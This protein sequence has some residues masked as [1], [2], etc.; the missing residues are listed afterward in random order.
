MRPRGSALPQLPRSSTVAGARPLGSAG[1]LL[2]VAGTSL[3]FSQLPALRSRTH[4]GPGVRI[5]LSEEI[6]PTRGL[7]GFEQTLLTSRAAGRFV[8]EPVQGKTSHQHAESEKKS[9]KKQQKG[10]KFSN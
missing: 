9:Q 1:T 7:P 6:M 5:R 3:G 8:S 4:A 2:G 10:L